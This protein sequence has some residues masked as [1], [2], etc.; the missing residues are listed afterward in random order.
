MGIMSASETAVVSSQTVIR[1]VS[2]STGM[3]VGEAPVMDE[4]QVR[5]VVARSRAAQ[6]AWGSVPVVERAA[7]LMSYRD[8]LMQRT[9]AMVE[10]IVRETG[11]PRHEALLHEIGA[12]ADLITYY[13]KNGPRMLAPREV[14]LRLLRHRRSYLHFAPRGVIGVIAPWN[15][16]LV[17]P[18]SGVIPALLSGSA[19][20][21]KPSEATSMVALE[22]KSIWDRAGLPPDL[23]TVVTGYADTAKALL[24]AGIQMVHFTGSVANGRKV[25]AACAE[26]L[27]PCILEL[28]GKAPLLACADA[29]LEVTANHAVYG[30]FA[31]AG[32]VCLSVERL[33]AHE[34]I[35]DALVERIVE[36]TRRLKQDDPESG[37]VDV[38]AMT[39]A[40]QMEV[41]DELVADALDKGAVLR[42]GGRRAS[43]KG[44]FY[45]PTV[46]TGCDHRMRLMNEEL[47]GPVL[48]IMKVDSD[49]KAVQLANDSHLGLNAYV[50]SSNRERARKLAERVRAGS[51]LINDVLSNYAAPEVP[52]GGVKDSGIGRVHGEQALQEMCETRHVNYER[53]RPF[54]RSPFGFPYTAQ[55]FR[56]ML[57]GLRTLFSGGDVVQKI[58]DLL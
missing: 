40:R 4:A 46:I 54:T 18:M 36:L 12:T 29:D 42:S 57:R 11:K 38:G 1:S 52:F 39:V 51:V 3:L 32:Q 34:A 23:F 20:V 13:A 53:V 14:P 56:W 24:D 8:A 37:W 21:L 5:E 30:A 33:Y 27:M 26:R 19:V 50:F 35:H 48:P 41:L 9:E 25:A 49:D 47:F 43:R 16:P 58:S 6:A 7:A 10:L 17:I 55:R 28:G 22:A 2:P 31:N 45:L 15:F 44:Q